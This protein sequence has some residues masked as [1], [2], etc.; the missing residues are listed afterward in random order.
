[1]NIRKV[2]S[3]NFRTLLENAL[4]TKESDPQLALEYCVQAL[5]IS[6]NNNKIVSMIEQINMKIS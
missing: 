3:R 1:M 2:K 5:N 4:S 6:P